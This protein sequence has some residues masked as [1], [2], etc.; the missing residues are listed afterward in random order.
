M[1]WSVFDIELPF[2]ECCYPFGGPE[3]SFPAM[4]LCSFFEQLDELLSVLLIK[5]WIRAL[6]PLIG[7]A[8]E[9]L[10][11]TSVAFY[12]SDRLQSDGRYGNCLH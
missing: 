8:F 4:S 9:S 6:V 12:R 10:I 1:A 11:M 2:D 7:S 3:I 5:L